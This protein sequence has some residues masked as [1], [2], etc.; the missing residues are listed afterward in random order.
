MFGP[1][2]R[3]IV[4]QICRLWPVFQSS[5]SSILCLISFYFDLLSWPQQTGLALI[6]FR[7][8]AFRLLLYRVRQKVARKMFCSFLDNSLEFKSEILHTFIILR[9]RDN[10]RISNWL[11][12]HWS[13]TETKLFCFISMCGQFHSVLKFNVATY[14]DFSIGLLKTYE[15]HPFL[16]MACTYQLSEFHPTK[17]GLNSPKLNRP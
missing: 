3:P 15:Q 1:T 8:K 14:S 6:Y 7:N 17:Y 12:A 5:I 10:S 11:N 2:C 9:A 4:G 16:K 13:E